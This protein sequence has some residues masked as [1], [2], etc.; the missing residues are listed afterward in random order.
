MPPSTAV[1]ICFIPNPSLSLF[2]HSRLVSQRLSI[3]RICRAQTFSTIT[4]S[5]NSSTEET[6]SRK[7][8]DV[9]VIGGGISGFSTAARLQANG[10][11]TAILES[12]SVL[13]QI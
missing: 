13:G 5:P 2:I 8:Y 10:I 7:S 11:Q 3:S 1:K 12:H 4:S 9:V 6:H